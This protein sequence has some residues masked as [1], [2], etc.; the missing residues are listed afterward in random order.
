[1]KGGGVTERGRCRLQ[2]LLLEIALFAKDS[3][4]HLEDCFKS[5]AADNGVLLESFHASLFDL[6]LDLLPPPTKSSDLR[7]LVEFSCG[8]RVEG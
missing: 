8:R 6:V 5:F 4:A 3:A 2:L 1:M 7:F